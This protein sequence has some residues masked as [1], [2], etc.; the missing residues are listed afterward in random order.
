MHDMVRERLRPQLQ[1]A[2]AQA[3]SMA[4]LKLSDVQ[5]FEGYDASTI[6]L[7]N[8]LEGYGFAEPGAGLE[9]FKQGHAAVGGK[10]PTNVN[11]GLLSGSYM[12]GWGQ[13]VEVVR[14]LRH[15]AGPR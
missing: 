3:L 5:H 9:F 10:I 13:I 14:Q 1:E 2:G 7:V 6:H 12:H 8:Q 11:G 15:E 4:G